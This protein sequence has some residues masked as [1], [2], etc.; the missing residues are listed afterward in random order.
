MN[1]GNDRRMNNI[2]DIF[3]RMAPSDT[4]GAT[5][6]ICLFT[7]PVLPSRCAPMPRL[8]APKVGM[9]FDITFSNVFSAATR[10]NP[11][12]HDGAVMV[13][14]GNVSEGYRIVGWSF[15]LF[16]EAVVEAEANRGS[17]FNSAQAMSHVPT[18][19]AVYLISKNDI[20]RFSSREFDRLR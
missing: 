11:A 19:D 8:P 16:P 4:G 6:I 2:D 9:P 20:Y 10:E 14:R 7:G 5:V 18:V 15:R 1:G 3:Q 17:A 13:G 12:I